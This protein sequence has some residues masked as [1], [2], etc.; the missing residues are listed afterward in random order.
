[1]RT[2][3]EN[4]GVRKSFHPLQEPIMAT[5]DT[6]T[7]DAADALKAAAVAVDDGIAEGDAAAAAAAATRL[8]RIRAY[9]QEMTVQQKLAAGILLALLLAVIVGF[10]MWS[11]KPAYAVLFSNLEHRDAGAIVQELQARNVTYHL[12][13]G[14]TIM[15]PA[16]QVHE[17]RLQLAAMG[18]P[19][20]ALVGFEVMEN[21]KLGVS[22]FHEQVNYQRALEGELSRTIQA[23]HSV[24]AARVHL[25]IPRQTGFLRDQQKPS[26]SVMVTLYPGR[27]LSKEQVAGIVHLIAS[28]VPRLNEEQVSV[29]D[30]DGD[31]LT[32][33]PDEDERNKLDAQQLAWTR[34]LEEGY[35][36]RIDSLLEAIVGRGNFKAQAAAD[37]DFSDLEETSE[38]YKPNPVPD[39]AIRSQ[40]TTESITRNDYARGV[41]GAL[42]NQPP[43]PAIAPITDPDIEGGNFAGLPDSKR[44][45]T[46]NYEL[47]RTL[48]HVRQPIGRLKRLTVAVVLNN[49]TEKDKKGKEYTVPIPDEEIQRITSLVREAMGFNAA[50]GDSVSV[51][52]ANFAQPVEVVV[53]LWKDPAVVAQGLGLAKYLA[54]ALGLLIVYLLIIRPLVRTLFPEPEPTPEELL[55]QQLAEAA[56]AADA[57]NT[58]EGEYDEDEDGEDVIVEFSGNTNLT[59]EQRIERLR[60]IARDNPK[61]IANIIKDWLTG[62]QKK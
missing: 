41:P 28:S 19:K 9:V 33:K 58:G 1:M 43:V 23:L 2:R 46:I 14:G 49:R 53:P 52:S 27:Y 32:R 18:L 24:S 16:K 62:E 6:L 48:Q 34:E 35:I 47:N 56:A 44:S 4:G 50:R 22:Q 8:E 15:V 45:A 36:R 17:L 11:H 12:G 21:Q 13:D 60:Q 29:V 10:A 39:Q 57:F 30:Q 51:T 7:A 55:E 61:L 38:L 37:V 40:Q 26:A 42:T 3:A 54:L 20:G 5:A 31:L 59:Y 25:A